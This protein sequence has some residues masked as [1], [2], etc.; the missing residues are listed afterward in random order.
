M[1]NFQDINYN[2]QRLDD[3]E[4]RFKVRTG[5][6]IYNV[7]GDAICG[8][9][10]LQIVEQ[11]YSIE[12]IEDTVQ[13]EIEF[14][15]TDALASDSEWTIIFWLKI[16]APDAG[17][18]DFST[19]FNGD[20]SNFLRIYKGTAGHYI[21]LRQGGVSVVQA[22][23]TTGNSFD[24]G[25]WTHIVVTNTPT[26][27]GT[28]GTRKIYVN[29]TQNHAGTPSGDDTSD[30]NYV[31][32][33]YGRV[34]QGCPDLSYLNDLAI[35][36]TKA[37]SDAEIL[38]IYN[39]GAY[40]DLSEYSPEHYFKFNGN[41]NNSGTSGQNLTLSGTY[42]FSKEITDIYIKYNSLYAAKSTSTMNSHG[43]YKVKD[44][45]EKLENI[46]LFSF[47]GGLGDA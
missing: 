40:A 18:S 47:P 19:Y 21:T 42:N 35:F 20:G 24:L 13:P 27:V 23:N 46:N 8:E 3:K 30:F 31:G 12:L 1:M 9:M 41:G 5:E 4:F 17:S 26:G 22:A 39:Q 34:P 32:R 14:A 25:E 6:D 16:I 28:T 33:I 10:F 45:T 11:P 15:D 44:L 29:G 7:T 43:I 38:S 37:L 36:K 2:G